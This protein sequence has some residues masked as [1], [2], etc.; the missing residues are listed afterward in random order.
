MPKANIPTKLP[1]ATI[2]FCVLVSILLAL[3]VDQDECKLRVHI[4]KAKIR[5]PRAALGIKMMINGN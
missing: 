3:K 1:K 5:A 4:H 2:H